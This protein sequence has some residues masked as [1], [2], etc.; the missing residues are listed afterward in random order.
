MQVI[1]KIHNILCIAA[2]QRR[3]TRGNFLPNGS[4][5]KAIAPGELT[6]YTMITQ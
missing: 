5:H 1:E 2:K 6:A 4:F 3:A